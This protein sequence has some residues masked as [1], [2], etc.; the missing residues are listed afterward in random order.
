[1]FRRRP[2]RAQGTGLL[3]LGLAL[4]LAGLAR[5]A[6]QKPDLTPQ[7]RQRLE[8]QAK[9]CNERLEKFNGE[10]KL[11][12]SLRE[13]QQLLGIAQR[14]YP[15]S[16]Y[17]DGHPDL[18]ASLQNLG[19]VLNSMGRPESALGYCEQA[20]AM[21]RRLYPAAKYP[22]GHFLLATI[23]NNLGAALA[24]MGRYE[25]ALDSYQQALAMG[26]RLYPLAKYPDGHPLL[27]TNL[28]SLGD[29]L[30]V[31]GRYESA[32]GFHE[33][34]LEMKRRLYPE[35]KYPDGHRHLAASLQD[36][37]F[38][39]NS[40]GRPESALGYCEQAL[41]MRRKLYPP[42][43]YPD[44]HPDLASSF[45]SL[46]TVLQAMGRYEPALGYFEQARAMRRRLYPETRYPT[47]HP[48]LS[49]SLNNLGSVLEAMGRYEPTLGYYEQAM[50]MDRR[51]YPEANYPAGH[52]DLAVDL[53]NLGLLLHRMGR[54]ESALG[55]HAEALAMARRLYPE[56][57]YPDGHLHLGGCLINLGSLLHSMGRPEAALGYHEEAVAM[58]RRLYPPA[59]Y[60]DGHPHL[61]AC[62]GH[63]GVELQAMGR[64]EP[65]LGYFEQALAMKRRLYPEAKYPTGHPDLTP[66][67]NHLGFVL[68]VMGRYEG[69]LGYHAEALAMARRL[70]P[71]SKYPAGH[72]YIAASL[73]NLGFVL[74][75]MGRYEPALD[76]YAQALAMNSRLAQEFAGSATESEALAF[77]G[78]LPQSLDSFLSTSQ[79]L[80]DAAARAWPRVWTSLAAIAR[81]GEARHDAL[82]AAELT[83]PAREQMEILLGTR[84]Q[85]ARL[86]LQPLPVE[87]KARADRDRRVGELT[88]ARERLERELARQVPALA[89]RQ[90][91]DRIGPED[92]EQ[93]LPPHAAYVDLLRYTRSSFDPKRPGKAGWT[94]TP[95]YVAF[96]VRPGQPVRRLELGPAGPIEEAVADWRHAIEQSR[97][98]PAAERLSRLVWEPIAQFLVS[99]TQTIY[100]VPDGALARLPWVALP[101]TKPGTVLLEE[102]Q[103]PVVPHGPYLVQELRK[104]KEAKTAD[105][106]MLIVGDVKYDD[107]PTTIEKP[108][109]DL[110]ALNRGPSREGAAGFWRD[111][112][113]SEEELRRLR[114]LAGPDAVEVTGIEAST[115][116]LLRELPRAHL[117]HLATHGFFNEKDFRAEQRRA[118]EAVQNWQFSQDNPVGLGGAGAGAMSPL[119]YTG[120]VLAGAN[121][122][123]TAGPDGG[124][125]T[126]EMLL[127]LDLRRMDLAVLSACQTGLGAIA[128]GQCV[129]N[130]QRA[131]HVA[132]CKNVVASLWSVPDEATAA[133]MAV[134]YEELLRN[135]KP[136]LEALRAAQLFVYRNP[137]Q[138]KELAQRGAPRL[139]KAQRLPGSSAGATGA[140]AAAGRSGGEPSGR[141]AVKNWAGFVLSGP[142]T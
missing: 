126:G 48:D 78:R 96:V 109:D 132:G 59:K 27:A 84:R 68:E 35:S 9:E 98:S 19:F 91:R 87:P 47:G 114:Q 30:Q 63:L 138:I 71:E 139:E 25:P 97:D 5:G 32:L 125:L 101:G 29:V 69:A 120:L 21:C 133:L 129:Q 81:L 100:L 140:S 42:T 73:Q 56:A 107:A 108:K 89:E 33:Q 122:P 41:A 70:Y 46:G 26:R 6:D 18:A 16:K 3:V 2:T 130:L 55:Y 15:E 12:D 67:L 106:A 36:L 61:A 77:Q 124:I 28:N 24:A 74:E 136:P 116:R 103:I 40:M 119:S 45:N 14:L 53:I 113:G 60:P 38:V 80:P 127:G 93:A 54:R 121:H 131:F 50:A 58:F 52:P 72:Y 88:E 110:L 13:A 128:D 135:H 82:A 85:L 83:G 11:T 8:A 43:K 4:S 79:P 102:L 66:S 51:L 23:L 22:A 17:P 65:A 117:A 31:M 141:A 7:E 90:E 134:F 64:P 99:E 115:A 20:L 92:L 123:E 76:Y 95:H 57:K 94:W 118:A 62:L 105:A 39:L 111:L 142:G 34:A 1:M 44:G 137:G 104:A 37:G 49:A 10:G 112:K 86:L 75:A